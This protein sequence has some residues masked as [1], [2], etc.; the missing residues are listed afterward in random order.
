M[1]NNNS[2]DLLVTKLYTLQAEFQSKLKYDQHKDKI[3]DDLHRE[4]Q[5]YK[6]DLINKK[7]FATD[8][9]GCHSCD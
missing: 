4:L 7:A 3:I 5:E 2:L 1:D 9:Y 6:S 8:D